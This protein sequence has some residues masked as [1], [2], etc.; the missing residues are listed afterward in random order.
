MGLTLEIPDHIAQGMRLPE[1]E[2]FPRVRLELAASLYARDI[3][4]FGKAAELAGVD[5]FQFAQVLGDRG[6]TRHYTE[7][8]LAQDLDY[9]RGMCK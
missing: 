1:H 8:E 9:A 3:L 4:G 6:M 2:R 7:V 5:R